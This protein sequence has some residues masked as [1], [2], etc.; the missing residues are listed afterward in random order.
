MVNTLITIATVRHR[1][2][3]TQQ[4]GHWTTDTGTRPTMDFT[5]DDA[6]AAARTLRADLARA[7]ITISHSMALELVA[8]QLGL[9]DWNT[10]SAV[11]DQRSNENTGL[12]A[13][14]PILR[15]Q[16]F[17]DLRSFYL[18][19]LGFTIE[20]EHRF[21]PGMPLYTRLVREATRLDLSEHH[22]DGT[23]GSVVWIPVADVRALHVELNQKNYPSMRPGID[24]DAPGGPTVT[25]IDASGNILRFCQPG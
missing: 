4:R 9:R 10:A 20:W 3:S 6:K 18:D 2:V 1:T 17:E 7:S 19:Y 22:G 13:P 21:G 25:V 23:P 16:R 14:V 11:L 5:T 24:R 15:V 8:H 12:G